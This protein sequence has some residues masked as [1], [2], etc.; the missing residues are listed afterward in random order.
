VN[1]TPSPLVLEAPQDAAGRRLDLFLH[2]K[3]P[4]FSRSRIQD[5][6]RWGRVRVGSAPSAKPS[7]VLRGGETIVVEPQE[8]APLKATP[9]N[10]PLRILYEDDDVVAIDKP[11]GMV[12]H[13]GA[14]AHSGT[15]VNALLHRFGSLSQLGGD[16][17]PGIVHR[18]DRY[19][20]GVLLVAK[21]DAAHLSLAKQFSTRA[22][23]KVYLALAH[24]VI[25]G[26]QGR[27]EKR[28]GRDP[29]RRVRM[30]ASD[31]YGR[32]ALT[33]YRVL[34]R[35]RDFSY[36]EVRIATGRTHQI[37][38]HLGSI[39]HPVAGDPLY[40]A[41]ARVPGMPPLDRF[42]LH[43]H[44]IGFQQPSTKESLVLESPLPPELLDW[45]HKLPGSAL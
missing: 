23:E 36:L 11:A 13:V 32:Q 4:Q 8:L 35:F 22:V 42:F 19:T 34:Q 6:I 33:Y 3:L 38:V 24:G 20:S 28:I 12:V 29:V 41:P 9:E 5:W 26:D 14:G 27:I 16:Q 40:G 43:A 2:E 37:R 31:H 17:R 39:G 1:P 7:L 45:M 44:H 21:H 30:M 18:L 10:I 15:L 25:A